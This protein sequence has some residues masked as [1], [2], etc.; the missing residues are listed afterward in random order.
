MPKCIGFPAADGPRTCSCRAC[1]ALAAFHP[2]SSR[3]GMTLAV[4]KAFWVALPHQRPGKYEE[5]A[6][7]SHAGYECAARLQIGHAAMVCLRALLFLHE[8]SLGCPRIL[9][10]NDHYDHNLRGVYVTFLSMSGCG[11]A[12]MKQHISICLSCMRNHKGLSALCID[13]QSAFARTQ[14]LLVALQ[15]H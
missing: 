14:R 8:V 12:V 5:L 11:G 10:P 9:M 7:R 15:L 4:H 1:S 6:F 13:S 3:I 2:A